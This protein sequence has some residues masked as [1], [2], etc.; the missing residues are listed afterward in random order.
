MDFLVHL[1]NDIVM[2]VNGVK[3][4]GSKQAAKALKQAPER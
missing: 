4:T 1:Q 2:S 3:V